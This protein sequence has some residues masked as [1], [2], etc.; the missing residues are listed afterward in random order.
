MAPAKAGQAVTHVKLR[1]LK[2][3]DAKVHNVYAHTSATVT[4]T[5][6]TR[7]PAGLESAIT[8]ALEHTESDCSLRRIDHLWNQP[9][10]D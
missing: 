4:P 1:D 10:G 5:T 2:I 9:A 8:S 6:L 3:P 7:F